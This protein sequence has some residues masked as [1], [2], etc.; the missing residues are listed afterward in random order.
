MVKITNTPRLFG[1]G[2]APT[3]KE[4][5][6]DSAPPEADGSAIGLGRISGGVRR[7]YYRGYEGNGQRLCGGMEYRRPGRARATS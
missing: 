2:F 5:A 1:K 7:R 3:R 6:A 4:N